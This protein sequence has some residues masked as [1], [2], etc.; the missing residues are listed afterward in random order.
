[1]IVSF[2]IVKLLLGIVFGVVC[3]CVSGLFITRSNF[4]AM[5]KIEDNDED[6]TFYSNE[7]MNRYGSDFYNFTEK[8]RKK[9][10]QDNLKYIIATAVTA[11]LW[12][13]VLVF[14][15][16]AGGGFGGNKKAIVELGVGETAYNENQ[17]VKI[18]LQPVMK[19]DKGRVCIPYEITNYT[20]KPLR[21]ASVESRVN[22]SGVGC[23]REKKD[24]SVQDGSLK[25]LATDEPIIPG[26]TVI[27]YVVLNSTELNKTGISKIESI[28]LTFV[29]N[30]EDVE[31]NGAVENET[32]L[33]ITENVVNQ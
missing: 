7:Q 22:S 24:N 33:A 31:N 13:G 4:E 28:T 15:I 8:R 9:L 2:S 30:T 25:L 20:D 17:V 27:N 29:T 32:T 1:M 26:S 5:T 12:V 3:G 16:N 14:L 23:T 11:V 19:D 21:V 6:M 18:T 10:A